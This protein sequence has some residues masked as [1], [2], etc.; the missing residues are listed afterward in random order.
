MKKIILIGLMILTFSGCSLLKM[1]N[2]FNGNSSSTRTQTKNN[3]ELELYRDKKEGI[4]IKKIKKSSEKIIPKKTFMEKIGSFFGKMKILTFIIILLTFFFPTVMIP[5][6][7]R[8]KKGLGKALKGTD[9]ILR[10]RT[11][12]LTETIR[13]IKNSGVINDKD[14]NEEHKKMHEK[15]KGAQTEETRKIIKEILSKI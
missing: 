3:Y 4:L 14:G 2:L 10:A 6:L 12:A 5:I 7:L 1:P 15:L 9:E 8:A 11:A 13:G